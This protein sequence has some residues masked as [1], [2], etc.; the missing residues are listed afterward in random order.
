MDDYQQPTG[1]GANLEPDVPR[2]DGEETPPHSPQDETA[3]SVPDQVEQSVETLMR[4]VSPILERLIDRASRGAAFTA[5]P[6]QAS[7]L[8][9]WVVSAMDN[10]TILAS[11]VEALQ[12][13]LAQAMEEAG[14]TRRTDSGLHIPN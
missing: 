6:E 4:R 14:P 8:A 7:I 9:A 10:A 1:G 12:A 11:Q 2:A 5:T 3:V 13:A